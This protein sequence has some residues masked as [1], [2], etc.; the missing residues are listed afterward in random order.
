MTKIFYHTQRLLKLP[1]NSQIIFTVLSATFTYNT[2]TAKFGKL[3]YVKKHIS[4]KTNRHVDIQVRDPEPHNVAGLSTD[5]R[6]AAAIDRAAP[7]GRAAGAA[8]DAAA[9]PRG[10]DDI[11]AARARRARWIAH[12][13]GECGDQ[14]GYRLQSAAD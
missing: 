14:Q 12:Q 9:Q 8:D 6:E 7:L 4:L 1:K 5:K 3:N 11:S 10:L 13:Q 2:I